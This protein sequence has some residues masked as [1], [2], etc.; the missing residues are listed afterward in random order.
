[1]NDTKPLHTH[2]ISRNLP[3]GAL[4][5]G[6]RPNTN[7]PDGALRNGSRPNTNLPDGALRNGS[8]PDASLPDGA[9]RAPVPRVLLGN[10]GLSVSRAGFGVLP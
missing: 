5:N 1:M 2:S 4:R 8:R 10:T 7:L 6:S 3:D 9:L